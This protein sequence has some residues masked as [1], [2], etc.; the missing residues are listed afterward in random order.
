MEM[1]FQKSTHS[2]MKRVLSQVCSNEQ[3]QDI[4]IGEEMPE[5]GR[6]IACWGQPMIRS[7]EWRNGSVGASGGVVA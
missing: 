6:I 5:I 4:R 1:E 7:K 3:T 2:Y